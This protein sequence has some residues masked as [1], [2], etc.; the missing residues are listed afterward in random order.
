MLR[1]LWNFISNLGISRK[2]SPFD[3]KAVKLMNQVSFVVMLWFGLATIIS[4]FTLNPMTIGTNLANVALFGFV[5]V[6]HSYGKTTFSRHYFLV[7]GLVMVTF[8][9]MAFDASSFPMVQFITT[10][11]FPIL[12]FRKTRTALIYL[13]FNLLCLAFVLWYH[14]HYHP[15]IE[16]PSGGLLPTAYVLVLIVMLVIFLISLF[17]RNVGE[18]LE[19]KLVEKNRYLNEL[20]EQL[21]SMQEQMI[22]SEKMA[23]LGQLTAGIAHEINNPVNFVSANISPLKRDLKELKELCLRVKDLQ[24]SDDPKAELESIDAYIREI[25]PEFLYQ[26]IETLINGIEE[27]AGRTR[28]IVAGLRSFSRLDEDD[29][30][31][32][33]IQQGIESTLMLLRNKI[34]NRI[35][36]RKD[37]NPLPP[38]ECVPGKINQVFMNI[39]N[40]ASDAIGDKGLITIK[41]RTGDQND[42]VIS[43]KDDGMGMK[44]SVKRR[45]FEPFYTTKAIGQGTGLGLSISYGIIEKHN[46]TIAVKSAPGK[47][48]EFIITLPVKQTEKDKKGGKKGF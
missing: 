46:G 24:L 23:S 36:V 3:Q 40:N 10:A 22:S 31:P 29:F 8:V 26:E 28:E 41:T 35:E 16:A 25:D 39:I 2:L 17:F 5:L 21:K 15:L 27:G 6:L 45:I 42:V 47:G 37:F 9:N 7:F 30:K 13:L 20:V 34:K 33:D 4:L 43:I 38:V 44:E 48:T 19:R 14:Q 32:A 18:D 12:I 1:E 11:I